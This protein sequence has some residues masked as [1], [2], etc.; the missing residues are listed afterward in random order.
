MSEHDEHT[1]SAGE[2]AETHTGTEGQTPGI[3]HNR[4]PVET[5]TQDATALDGGD[6]RET[7]AETPVD[8]GES[9]QPRRESRAKER[10]QELVS[11]AKDAESRAEQAERQL[12]QYESEQL[13]DA[14]EYESDADY[15]RAI[16]RAELREAERER[17]QREQREAAERAQAERAE[18]FRARAEDAK[19][20]IPDF[21]QVALSDR[22]PYSPS[23]V[24]LV[25]E[26][27]QGPEIA[28]HL[29]KN[30]SEAERIARLT[31]L[32]AAREIGR[33]ESRFAATAP[34]KVSTAP[35]PPKTIS[36]QGAQEERT[37]DQMSYSEYKAWRNGQ[38][39]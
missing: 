16:I 31:P 36:G 22:V 14:S 10:I 34:K 5:E 11:R 20:R 37:P 19:A 35:P 29:G 7:G 28:Y 6:A 15:Q 2:T 39:K 25:Q 18:I 24:Q 13:R 32:A 33:L 12:Q 8:Q 9:D 4:P 3:G 21:E 23:M 26:S 38:R 27:E 1:P 30:P 17:W